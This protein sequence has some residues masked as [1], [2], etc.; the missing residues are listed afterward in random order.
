MKRYKRDPAAA[1]EDMMVLTLEER[2]AYNTVLD[3]IFDRRGDVP[4]DDRFLASWMRCDTRIWRRI[5]QRLVA[6]K[7]IEIVGGRII[8]H[9][10]EIELGKVI[11]EI[12][13]LSTPTP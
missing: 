10:A 9:R 12:A 1:L 3:L 8:N 13:E 4:D 2:G 5:K 7:K 6:L 11:G